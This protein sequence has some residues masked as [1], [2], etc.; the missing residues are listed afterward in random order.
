MELPKTS[1][2]FTVDFSSGA[3]ELVS[4][5][6][7][8]G[9]ELT[10]YTKTSLGDGRQANNPWLQEMPDPIT[11]TSWDNYVTMSKVDAEALG[12]TNTNVANGALN[13][14]YLTVSLGDKKIS[15]LPVI[16]QPGQAPG[17]IGIALGYG[18]TESIQEEM[19]VG[20]NAFPLYQD[21]DVNQ[22][23][24]GRSGGWYS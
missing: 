7:A 17:S 14:N 10:L 8:E 13:G 20:V 23:C 19:Q 9:F 3:R 11:R 15:K 24:H 2:T 5:N 16:I 4:K 6:N 18:K 12:L 1:E 21:F 22:K